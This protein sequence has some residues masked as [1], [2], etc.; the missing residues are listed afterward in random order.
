MKVSSYSPRLATCDSCQLEHGGGGTKRKAEETGDDEGPA[1]KKQKTEEKKEETPEEKE[2]REQ[3]E[4][5]WK[6]KDAL[7]DYR[8]KDL[9]E[10][11]AL[12]NQSEKGGTFDFSLRIFGLFRKLT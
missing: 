10:I 1:T 3:T 6:I 12:N 2:K 4:L 8:P 9:K 5:M 7:K 11:C